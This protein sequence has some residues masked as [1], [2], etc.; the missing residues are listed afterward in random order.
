MPMRRINIPMAILIDLATPHCYTTRFS[1][2]HN[3]GGNI[4]FSDGHAAYFKYGYVVADGVK[5]AADGSGAVPVAGHDLG[6]PD[7]NWDC[8]GQRVIN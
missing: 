4:T 2:R 7:V 5:T 1:S 8:R 3:R 6:E